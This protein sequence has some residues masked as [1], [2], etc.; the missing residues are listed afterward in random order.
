VDVGFQL[1]E[2]LR[3][4][5]QLGEVEALDGV[6]L[7]DLDNGHREVATYI[8]QP[9]RDRRR[10]PRQATDAATAGGAPATLLAT[11][12]ERTEGGV[13]AAVVAVEANSVAVAV[14]ASEYES[15]AAEAFGV[16]DTRPQV[17]VHA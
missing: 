12:V 11:V 2:Q 14:A 9:A 10:R 5:Q 17:A 8:A 16:R 6:A 15:P 13:D 1:G 4:E 7:Q 3:F